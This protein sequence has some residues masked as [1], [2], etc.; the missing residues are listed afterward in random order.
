VTDATTK[1]QASFKI[2]PGSPLINLYASTAEEFGQQLDSLGD[3][4]QKIDST[5]GVLRA[6]DTLI[7]EFKEAEA[8]QAAAAPAA[9]A[10]GQGISNPVQAAGAPPAGP[11]C[12]HGAMT[13]KTGIT[14]SG[15]NAGKEWKA[16]MC[17]TQKDGGPTLSGSFA[18]QCPAQW[19]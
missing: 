13:Y 11:Q 16:W 6:V 15:R 1:F 10:Q 17:P 7:R 18:P 8:E 2:T 3:L 19:L 14:K 4:A 5:A 12:V 9:P